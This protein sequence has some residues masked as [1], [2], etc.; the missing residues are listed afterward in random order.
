[1]IDQAFLMIFKQKQSL[2]RA[3]DSAVSFEKKFLVGFEVVDD[4]F[5]CA[6]PV[7]GDALWQVWMDL[8][9]GKVLLDVLDPEFKNIKITTLSSEQIRSFVLDLADPQSK[10]EMK[11]FFKND[12]VFNS[13]EITNIGDHSFLDVLT[14]NILR[15]RRLYRSYF[16]NFN[17]LWQESDYSSAMQIHEAIAENDI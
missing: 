10:R 1:M 5:L 4:V 17:F 3:L 6:K 16:E 14:V 7:S 15:Y 2:A 12:D 13:L 11:E 8:N 9:A